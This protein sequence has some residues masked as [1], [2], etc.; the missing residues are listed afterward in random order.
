MFGGIHQLGAAI[1]TKMTFKTLLQTS[2][3]LIRLEG[4]SIYMAVESI[5]HS[6]SIER[7]DS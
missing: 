5:Q 2:N 3:Q 4:S 6:S 1:T 7:K